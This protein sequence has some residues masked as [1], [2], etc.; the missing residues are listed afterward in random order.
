VNIGL[1]DLQ[2]LTP[3]TFEMLVAELL[4]LGGFQN[5]VLLGG[6]GD[7]GVDIRAE[8]REA[9][10]TGD[11][12]TTTWAV[13][14][15]RNSRSIGPAEVQ[16]ILSWMLEPP[17]DLLPSRPDFFLLATSSGLTPN[18]RRIFERAN[19]NRGKYS[20]RFVV[21][22][23]EAL[24]KQIARHESVRIKFFTVPPPA[25]NAYRQDSDRPLPVVR[26]SVLLDPQG[27]D[28]LLTFLLESDLIE[29]NT[30]RAHMKVRRD[31]FDVLVRN[32]QELAS[33]A[34]FS[35]FPQSGD[36]D[37]R[38][39]GRQI[40]NL[41]PD[42]IRD[43]LK[44][45]GDSYIRIASNMHIVPFELASDEE[46]LEFLGAS[47]RV[48]RI[49]ISEHATI[50]GG[51]PDASALV[52]GPIQNEAAGWLPGAE[53]EMAAISDILSS[54]G[55]KVSRLSGESLTRENLN[56]MTRGR[57]IVHFAGHGVFSDDAQPGLLLADGFISFEELAQTSLGNVSL[58][59][60]SACSS[61]VA[62][63]D[64]SRKYFYAGASAFV[65]FVGPV[66]ERAATMITAKFYEEIGR[67]TTLGDALRAAKNAQRIAQ[68]DDSSW[69][70]LVLFGDPTRRIQKR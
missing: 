5:V 52:V 55:L 56:A 33:T 31:A 13:Q 41:I 43:I 47:N 35:E 19:L 1:S 25:A 60:L 18:A 10:P 48:G 67:G 61:G 11:V 9:L 69:A 46:S 50:P 57:E 36:R 53:E 45:Q 37:L 70:S 7:E 29:P 54:W 30:Q 14:C 24:I 22:D 17:G 28:V 3:H 16:A 38:E 12:L 21:W 8:W 39:I 40:R 42:V 15:K 34:M 23:G 4:E 63:N 65:A 26:L 62:L 58:V 64:A 6:P 68:P 66:T 49:Q 44:A 20:C 32:C 2:G 27:D 59:V 51:V